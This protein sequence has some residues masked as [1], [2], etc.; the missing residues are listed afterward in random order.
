MCVVTHEPDLLDLFEIVVDPDA[1]PTDLD[2]ALAE[3]L[4]R[5]MRR[6]R[7]S[8]ASSTADGSSTIGSEGRFPE[9]DLHDFFEVVVGANVEAVDPDKV[10]V[11]IRLRLVPC[12]QS[13]LRR[14]SGSGELD[15]GR[16]SA[17]HC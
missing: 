16:R 4:L 10:L 8:V 13:K 12:R 11:E 15:Q 1:E 5:Y 14:H 17:N 9:T 3:F 2:E 7:S 6:N